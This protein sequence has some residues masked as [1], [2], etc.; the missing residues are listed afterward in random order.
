MN[1]IDLKRILKKVEKPARYLGNEINS[2]HKDTSNKNLIRYAHCF[3]DLYEVGMSH[4]GSHILYDVINKDEDVFCERVYAPA[5]DMENFMR[6][7]NI[8]MFALESREPITNFD[9]VVF[10]LQYELSYTNILNILD[11]A[12]I[13][14][15]R[16]ERKLD[17]PFIMVGGPCAYNVEPLADFVDIAILG[18]GEEVNLEVLNVYKKWKKNK[19][20][21]E[22]FLHKI[23]KI[24]GVYIPSFYD[25]TYN[26]DNTVKEVKPNREGIPSKVKKR[27]IKNVEDVPYPEKLIVPF[28]DTVHNR[29]VLELFRGCTRGCRFCQAGMIYRP[30]REKSLDRLKEIVDKLVKNTGYDEISLSSLSTSDYSKLSELT[31]F[32]VEEYTPKN[33]G[34][35]L[36]SL[37]LDNFSMEIAEKIQQVRKSGLTFAPE[38]GTQRMRDVI[39]KGISEEDL[40][41]ATRKAFEMG[42]DSV[43]LY[44][45]IGLPTERYDDLDGIA[46][47]AYGVIDTYKDVNGGKIRNKFSVTVS[48][49]TFVPKPF[50]PFQWHGQDT[51]E[52]VIEKQR[53]L[54]KKLKNGNIKYNYHDSKTSLMEAVVARGDRKIGKVI[55]D[56]FKAGAKFDGWSEYFN[57]D[58]WKEA[59][60]KNG[61]DIAFYANREREYEEVF[62]WDHIDVGV[63]KKFLI[64]ENE[65]SKQDAVSPDCRH[66]CNGCGVNTNDIGRGLC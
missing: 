29:V 2:I 54:I 15:L 62:P 6:E 18:E 59:M 42:W 39:N 8:P 48:T 20:T 3:P 5:V 33:I 46:D 38:A 65:K 36:P 28:I 4:L 44:F 60:A 10:T 43:K 51:T 9:F 13:P 50:T 30:I 40:A 27:I 19:T 35:S 56:A 24:E 61:L 57:L 41:N 32:L 45:M 49:S 11:L 34:I 55:Y 17:D 63:T 12:N 66:K 52:E 47:L 21:R 26:E 37:R 31:D 23:A 22:D 53:H 64:R 25:V 58:I 16:S 1:K 14:L 7:N